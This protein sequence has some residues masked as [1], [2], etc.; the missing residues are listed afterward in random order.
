MRDE[1]FKFL[2]SNFRGL[3]FINPKILIIKYIQTAVF[4]YISRKNLNESIKFLP[5]KYNK[6]FSFLQLEVQAKI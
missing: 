5:K 1:I 3:Y 6:H 4:Q 2:G